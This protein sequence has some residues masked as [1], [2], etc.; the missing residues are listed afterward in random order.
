M[1]A[2]VKQINPSSF[3]HSKLRGA[4]LAHGFT[5]REFAEIIGVDASTL[6]SFLNGKSAFRSVTIVKAAYA[7]GVALD[8]RQ[9]QE[10]FFSL[11]N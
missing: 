11:H 9:F 10:L 8:S 3:D 5:E 4:I 2:N 6:S 1:S 7:L